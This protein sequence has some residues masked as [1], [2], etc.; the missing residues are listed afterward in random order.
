MLVLMV[1]EVVV[2]KAASAPD[3]IALAAAAPLPV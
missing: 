1:V 3:D 2:M